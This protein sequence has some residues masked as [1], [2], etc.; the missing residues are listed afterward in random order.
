MYRISVT[1]DASHKIGSQS[2]KR[3]LVVGRTSRHVPTSHSHITCILYIYIIIMNRRTL[4]THRRCLEEAGRARIRTNHKLRY[5]LRREKHQPNVGERAE[6]VEVKS[7]KHRTISRIDYKRVRHEQVEV[8]R[9]K[10]ETISM[11]DYK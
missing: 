10:H 3:D 7:R 8:K 5:K 9:R 2:K 1:L 6:Q 11:L 4:F